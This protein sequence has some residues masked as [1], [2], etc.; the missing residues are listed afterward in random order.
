MEFLNRT[1]ERARLDALLDS[2]QGEF[3]CVYGRRRCGKTR[4]LREVI[5]KKKMSFIFWQIR[6]KRICKFLGLKMK[7]QYKFLFSENF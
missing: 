6:A 5:S 2:P 1:E 7:L 3:A 4:L